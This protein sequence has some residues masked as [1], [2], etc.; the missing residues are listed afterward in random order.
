MV[1]LRSYPTDIQGVAVIESPAALDERGYFERIFSEADFR[2][3]GLPTEALSQCVISHN[4]MRGT[5]RGMHYQEAPHGEAKLIRCLKGAIYDVALDLRVGAASYGRSVSTEL[6]DGSHRALYIPSGCAHGFLTLAPETTVLYCIFGTY[7][8]GAARVVRWNDPSFKISWP[9][10]PMCM[11]S[12][13][14]E[15]CDYRSPR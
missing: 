4:T 13:D 6:S 11:S 10:E 3:L 5:L 12:K 8:P 7:A 15:A 9:F 1:E 14:R 2:I